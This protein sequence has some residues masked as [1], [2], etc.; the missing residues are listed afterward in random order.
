MSVTYCDKA[1]NTRLVRVGIGGDNN[2]GETEVIPLA[3]EDNGKPMGCAFTGVKPGTYRVVD[4]LWSA[5]VYAGPVPSPAGDTHVEMACQRAC[6][7]M[8]SFTSE[9]CGTSGKVR[10]YTADPAP[11]ATRISEYDWAVGTP[12]KVGPTT[13]GQLIAEVDTPNCGTLVQGIQPTGMRSEI[14]LVL[15]TPQLV[16]LAVTDADGKAI[17]GA[18]V[19]DDAFRTEHADEQGKLS[20]RRVRGAPSMIWVQ[21]SGFGGGLFEVPPAASPT[22]PDVT[23]PQTIPMVVVLKPTH[24]VTVTCEQSGAPCAGPV[25]VVGEGMAARGCEATTASEW[26]CDA[27]DDDAAWARQGT[28]VSPR[29]KVQG[30]GAVTVVM[31]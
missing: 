6:V 12:L 27:T 25:V 21:A 17:P 14:K 7:D 13:C 24:P 22:V 28:A 10:V 9:L 8:V 2:I 26:Q 4:G 11:I 31:P 15:D 29:V 19:S 20:L 16:D 18:Y 30:K 23:P 5:I 1:E 3:C